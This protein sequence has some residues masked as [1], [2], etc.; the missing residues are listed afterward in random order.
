MLY[1]QKTLVLTIS[2]TVWGNGSCD[3]DLTTAWGGEGGGCETTLQPQS[4]D[5]VNLDHVAAIKP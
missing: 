2:R 5:R 3:F 4:G 1:A